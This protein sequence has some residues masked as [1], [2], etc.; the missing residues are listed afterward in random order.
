VATFIRKLGNFGAHAGPSL[1]EKE[2][3]VLE[4]LTFALLE[5]IYVAPEL[6]KRAEELVS[7][8]VGKDGSGDSD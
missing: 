8:M 6:L 2:A 3:Q 7:K 4:D 1:T 5:Y